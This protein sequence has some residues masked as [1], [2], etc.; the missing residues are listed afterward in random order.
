MGVYAGPE[1]VESGLVLALD[2]A[3]SKSYPGSGTTWTDLSG[4]GNNGTLLNGVGYSGDN[5]GSLVFDGVN[6][7][8][9]TANTIISGSQTFS[10]WASVGTITPG[11]DGILVQHNYASTANFGINHISTN[12]LAPSIGYTNGTREYQSKPTSFRPTLNI[13]FNAV[14]VYNS[15][16]N[17]IYWYING[18]LDSSYTLSATP[19]STN[20][21]ICLGRWDA[22]YGNYY[23]NGKVYSGNIYNRALTAAEIQQNFNANRSRFGI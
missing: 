15:P 2:A 22:G 5:L 19:K 9:T 10:V 14:L 11:L 3:N 23:F 4:N 1:V 7:Y 20:Y 13:V 8:S 21:P 12:K 17:K 16:E 6:D 18:Q